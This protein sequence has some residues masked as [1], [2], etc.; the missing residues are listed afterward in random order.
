MYLRE[1]YPIPIYM[2]YSNLPENLPKQLDIQGRQSIC[3]KYHLSVKCI[4][5]DFSY[6]SV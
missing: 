3:Q 5:V 6:T 1:L 4:R 2:L